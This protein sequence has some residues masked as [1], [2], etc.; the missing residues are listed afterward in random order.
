MAISVEFNVSL[1]NQEEDNG[2]RMTTIHFDDALSD[3]IIIVWPIEK[4]EREPI[5]WQGWGI[6]QSL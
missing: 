4:K 5:K 3:D 6:S 2:H 1:L